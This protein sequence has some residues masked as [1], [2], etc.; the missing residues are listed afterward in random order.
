MIRKLKK[1][2][3]FVAFIC[4]ISLLSGCGRANSDDIASDFGKEPTMDSATAALEDAQ[5]SVSDASIPERVEYVLESPGDDDVAAVRANVEADDFNNMKIVEM[6]PMV[7]DD[8]KIDDIAKLLFDNGEYKRI[9]PYQISSMEE[10]QTEQEDL[11]EILGDNRE[12]IGYEDLSDVLHWIEVYDETTVQEMPEEQLI[13]NFEEEGGLNAICRLRGYVDGELWE[14]LYQERE[15][16][17]DRGVTWI[18]NGIRIYPL[19]GTSSRF[20]EERGLFEVELGENLMS[21]ENALRISQAFLEGIG[22]ENLEPTWSY[23]LFVPT[24]ADEGVLDGY[25]ILFSKSIDGKPG[26]YMANDL[27]KFR[28]ETYG[29]NQGYASVTIDSSGISNVSVFNPYEMG[30]VMSDHVAMLDFWQVDEIARAYMTDMI[31]TRTEEIIYIETVTI[32]L[33]YVTIAYD[34]QY[35]ALPVWIYLGPDFPGLR[36]A[37]FGINAIDGELIEFVIGTG[38]YL[39]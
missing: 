20:F 1:G 17:N 6:T 2:I 32:S 28:G 29:A 7:I 5:T 23:D 26:A 27:A 31:S 10:L 36:E 30:E 35:V 22:F 25:C 13:Y 34:G 21:Y 11:Q 16:V 39:Y 33:A 4:C 15:C 8:E 12:L 37:N 38:D 24:G 18:E 19:C 3:F 14:L 9:K